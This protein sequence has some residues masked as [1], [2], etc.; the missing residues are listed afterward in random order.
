MSSKILGTSW[1]SDSDIS[2]KFRNLSSHCLPL[3]FR[4]PFEKLPLAIV[5]EFLITYM[6][7]DDSAISV[8]MPST[9]TFFQIG[10][11]RW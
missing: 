1:F 10:H 3:S 8:S 4:G 7:V 2:Q 11:H 6:A 9:S 5:M